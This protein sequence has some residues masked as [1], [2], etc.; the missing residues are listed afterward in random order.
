MRRC[1]CRKGLGLYAGCGVVVMLWMF[2]AGCGKVHE[3][4]SEAIDSMS[5]DSSQ[6]AA[7]VVSE[8]G[9]RSRIDV[10]HHQGKIDWEV[11]AQNLE[12]DF[13]YVKATEGASYIDPRFRENIEGASRVGY[14]VGVYH[15]FRMTSSAHDQF[16]NFI[17]A[18]GQYNQDVLPMVDVE[19]RDGKRVKEVRDSLKVFIGLIKEHYGVAPMIYATNRS[20]NEILA[21]EFNA[22]HLY[23]GRYGKNAPVIKG[24]GHYTIWQYTE[25]ARVKGIPKPVDM[26]TFHKDYDME[27][28][29]I[30]DHPT[31]S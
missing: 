24:Q 4:G 29:L 22:Y 28:L 2:C 14:K 5:M 11:V 8:R 6:V 16:N 18:V 31:G 21:P 13:V 26:A 30:P 15:F 3:E 23:I 20:Y 25:S 7:D 10:S 9:C 1:F 27:C 17:R 19:T 12:A